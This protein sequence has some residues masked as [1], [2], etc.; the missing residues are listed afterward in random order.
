MADHIAKT[1]G[2]STK[3]LWDYFKGYE[4]AH[5][6]F[7]LDTKGT[8]K[9]V[10]GKAYT[11]KRPITQKDWAEHLRGGTKGIGVIPLIEDNTVVWGCIDV[12]DYSI[13][14]PELS[15]QIAEKGYPLT[16]F[17]SKSGGSHLICF[18]STA[19]PAEAMVSRL[20]WMA[21]ELGYKPTIEIF[22]KQT[23]REID[24]ETGKPEIGN[25]LNMPYYGGKHTQRFAIVNGEP[26]TTPEQCE[27]HL[28]A[29]VPTGEDFMAA[30]PELGAGWEADDDTN[31]DEAMQLEPDT[32]ET[33]LTS[34]ERT[35]QKA[36]E[37]PSGALFADGPPCLQMW[38]ERGGFKDGNRNN[39]MFNVAT[40]AKLKHPN[41]WQ[42]HLSTYNQ[43]LADP[44]LTEKELRQTV[45]KSGRRR[46]YAYACKQPFLAKFCQ[47]DVCLTRTHGIA[48]GGFFLNKD[49]KP[50][51]DNQSNIRI[52][53]SRI[54]VS[55]SHDA[56][57]N[58]ML[59]EG[60]D[61][62]G[63]YLDDP[64][65]DHLWLLIDAAFKFRPSKSFFETV[66][67]EEARRNGFHPVLEYLDALKWDEKPR[68]DTWL[69]DYAGAE[70]TP[71]VRAV[72]SIHLIAAVR[73]VREPGCKYDEM[74]IL[75]GEQ[76]T[77]KSSALAI[78][79][80][81]DD[82]FSDDLPLNKGSKEVIEALSGRWILE[83]AELNKMRTTDVEHLKSLL[84]RRRDRARLSYDRMV[85]DVPRQS[86][87][88][89]TTNSEKY[90]YDQTGN[91]RY[92]PVRVGR[93]DLQ[94][95]LA[96][97][98]QLWAEAAA[99]EKKGESIRLDPKL[100]DVAAAEQKK[101]EVDEPYAAI[102]DAALTGSD[103]KPMNGRIMS[104]DVWRILR[105]PE[106]DHSPHL[107]TRMGRAMKEIGFTTKQMRYPTAKDSPMWFYVRGQTKE[108]QEKLIYA[109]WDRD[110]GRVTVQYF[111]RA[112][113]RLLYQDRDL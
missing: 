52:A 70:D 95:L 91:R 90:L 101:R 73:R 42:E 59:V 29:V 25:W 81:H 103:G 33:P 31:D 27:A 16:V 45:Q 28:D 51:K 35:E 98:D 92:W 39:L 13:S 17:R 32:A 15:K 88:F 61:R 108:E 58:R 107:G 24:P 18:V 97:R 2:L 4:H 9:K 100:W 22:P 50:V 69:I 34:P 78:M 30:W 36:T 79:A 106:K 6:V 68:L 19:I 21:K 104:L 111:N 72:S 99:R 38:A 55:L 74:L 7:E 1:T 60:L 84:S 53:L 109:Q 12:D 105:V 89:G 83:A 85:S 93:F 57:D 75:E 40:Y 48:K 71:F 20:R 41:D 56:F 102:L 76:G 67:R 86:V 8:G 64:A 10:E 77:N 80:V 3:K 94:K 26:L 5:G 11:V 49:K 66:L 63:P 47:R 54:G 62:I 14:P 82:W 46:D 113:S 96:N 87:L 43:L 44:P 110:R 65:A 37:A 23:S 112:E